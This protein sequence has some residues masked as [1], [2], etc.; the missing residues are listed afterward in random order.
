MVP[1]IALAC[2]LAAVPLA[3]QEQ[4]KPK[5][6]KDSIQ[7]V[8]DGCIKGRV[9]RAADVRQTDTTTGVNV[10]SSTFRLA[11]KK[12]VMSAVKDNDGSRV[13]V[14]GLI[15]KSALT[16]P[17]MKFKGGRIRIGG[18]TNGGTASSLPDPAENVVVLDVSNVQA[19]GGS[20]SG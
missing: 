8:I 6:P 2:L 15:K 10:T 1:R 16:E 4:E 3:A 19:L 11:G 20:C 12:D 17:G 5:I 18:G 7:V 14:T 9:L 13:E